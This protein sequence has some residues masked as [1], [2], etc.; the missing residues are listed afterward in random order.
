MCTATVRLG[1]EQGLNNLL[2]VSVDGD[3]SLARVQVQAAFRYFLSDVPAK[4]RSSH[5]RAYRH[6]RNVDAADE[7][8]VGRRGLRSGLSAIPA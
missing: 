3:M 5:N 8:T 4:G 1:G 7:A 2:D 6:Q